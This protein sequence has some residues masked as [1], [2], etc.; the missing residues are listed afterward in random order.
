M[1]PWRLS[2]R[3]RKPR[4]LPRPRRCFPSALRHSTCM[5]TWSRKQEPHTAH[6]T[7]L[8]I[9][10]PRSHGRHSGATAREVGGSSCTGGDAQPSHRATGRLVPPA[11]QRSQGSERCDQTLGRPCRWIRAR[12]GERNRRAPWSEGAQ[13]VIHT[14]WLSHSPRSRILVASGSFTWISQVVDR[15]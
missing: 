9:A 1:R 5:A 2:R 10:R 14:R 15:T 13:S 3:Q 12:W 6:H 4:W 8:G 11:M 7:S